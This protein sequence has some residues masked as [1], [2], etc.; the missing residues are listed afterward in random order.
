[1]DITT[2]EIAHGDEGAVWCI[3]DQIDFDRDKHA[4]KAEIAGHIGPRTLSRVL[5]TI[6]NL[7]HDMNSTVTLHEDR[8]GYVSEDGMSE[9]TLAIIA[10]GR[11]A[12][13]TILENPGLYW[14]EEY[15]AHDGHVITSYLPF[16]DDY[17]KFADTYY[18]DKGEYLAERYASIADS[19]EYS[20]AY[21]NKASVLCDMLSNPVVALA[22]RHHYNHALDNDTTYDA[23]LM[24]AYAED[25][26]NVV[27]A[28]HL[29]RVARDFKLFRQSYFRA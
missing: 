23:A 11:A 5:D 28:R 3:V 27:P 13:E 26:D 16:R 6:N 1:M 10:K 8:P 22:G 24:C 17:A 7:E 25:L 20:E 15:G 19:E 2:K 21:R 4:V 18:Y 14:S 29:K 12:Y 9:T